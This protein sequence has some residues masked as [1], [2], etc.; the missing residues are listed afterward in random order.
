MSEASQT[1]AF[2]SVLTLRFAVFGLILAFG[3]SLFYVMSGTYGD[4]AEIGL[5]C[6]MLI[7]MQLVFSSLLVLLLDE[8]LQKYG[9]GSGISLFIATNTCETIVWRAFSPRTNTVHGGGTEFEGAIIATV[10]LLT[11][12]QDKVRALREAFYRPHL[13]N[14]TNLIST[15][16]MFA[17]II[18]FQ[19]F[20]VNVPVK[21]SRYRG[22]IGSYPIKLFYTSNMPIIFQTSLVSSLF[23]ISHMLSSSMQ[24]NFLVRLLGHWSNES[25][26]TSPVSGLCYYLSTPESLSD[27]AADPIRAIFYLVF[28]LTTCALFS[29]Y[30]LN[31]SESSAKDVAKSLREQK[32]IMPGQRNDSMVKELNRYIPTAAVVGGMMLAALSVMADF[33]GALGSGTGILLAV[34]TIYQYF[35]IFIKEQANEPM[36]FRSFLS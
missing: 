8:L 21:S 17:I 31:F 28:M 14:L 4:P 3:Q 9:F 36:S 34:T 1:S 33:L 18:Y 16:V 6:C 25:G 32:Y 5:G 12:R 11:T 13:P 15:I 2:L 35:E 27:V 19:G 7:V 29:K 30:W 26:R 23:G 10:H 22:Q 24:D 20:R